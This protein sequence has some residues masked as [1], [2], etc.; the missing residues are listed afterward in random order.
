MR[1]ALVF[2]ELF[3]ISYTNESG[4]PMNILLGYDGSEAAKRF[5]DEH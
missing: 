3:E 2:E 1:S 4:E 5:T